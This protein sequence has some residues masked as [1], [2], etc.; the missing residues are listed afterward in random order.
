MVLRQSGFVSAKSDSA[1]RNLTLSKDQDTREKGMVS[2][3][4][5]LTLRDSY[6]SER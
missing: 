3:C 1:R 6:F 4:D 5:N 2:K